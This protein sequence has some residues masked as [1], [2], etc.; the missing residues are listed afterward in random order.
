MLWYTTWKRSGGIERGRSGC[1]EGQGKEWGR[2]GELQRVGKITKLGL[3]CG[4]TWV[5][6]DVLRWVAVILFL[7]F[8]FFN[9]YHHLC[10]LPNRPDALGLCPCWS[11]TRGQGLAG[12]SSGGWQL[13]K[14]ALVGCWAADRPPILLPGRPDGGATDVRVLLIAFFPLLDFCQIGL[15]PHP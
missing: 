3:S 6:H 8:F 7:F 12:K 10:F 4:Y 11:C 2:T 15:K 14:G 9:L 5:T 13:P 1:R